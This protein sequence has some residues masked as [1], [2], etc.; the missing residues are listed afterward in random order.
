MPKEQSP[1]F[2][3]EGVLGE[4]E[5]VVE[6]TEARGVKKEDGSSSTPGKDDNKGDGTNDDKIDDAPM[7]YTKQQVEVREEE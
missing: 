4:L 3:I 2:M 1:T 7:G 6:A 5:P